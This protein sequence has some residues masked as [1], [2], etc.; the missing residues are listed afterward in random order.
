MPDNNIS[1]YSK[2]ELIAQIKAFT[3]NI[4]KTLVEINQRLDMLNEKDNFD[5]KTTLQNTTSVPEVNN[6]PNTQNT[7][8]EVV[9]FIGINAQKE[10]EEIIKPV[11]RPSKSQIGGVPIYEVIGA[12][13]TTPTVAPVI[14][15]EPPISNI[16]NPAVVTTVAQNPIQ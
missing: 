3:E 1:N 12:P 16:G 8:E 5:V 10:A 13:I 11:P 15:E 7:K 14:V 9:D 4:E 6:F 2:N